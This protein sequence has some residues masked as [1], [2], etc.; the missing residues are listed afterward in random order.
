MKQ[1]YPRCV[2][3]TSVGFLLVCLISIAHA[4]QALKISPSQWL[5]QISQASAQQSFHGTFIYRCDAQLVAMKII[6]ATDEGK[7]HEKLISLNGPA[8]EVIQDGQSVTSSLFR[9]KRAMGWGVKEAVGSFEQALD[10]HYKIVEIGE[11]RIAE[12]H[13]K[14][15]EIRPSDQYRYGFLIWLDSE[16]GLVLRSDMADETGQVI[17]QIM[18]IDVEMITQREADA[19][20]GIVEVEQLEVSP[21][22]ELAK[23]TDSNWRVA[24]IPSGFKFSER[25]L[26]QAASG[27]EQLQEQLVF[28]DGLASVSVFIEPRKAS[29]QPLLGQTR[30]GA[31][32]VFG[33]VVREHQITVVG[34]VPKATVESIASSVS[35]QQ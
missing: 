27:G 22:T 30:I 28:T 23:L 20:I 5:Q 17:E 24:N 4:G 3:V 6:H 25:Y 7:G 26:R 11:D 32:N 14:V 34:D 12:R 21:T 15:V 16:T 19:M 10:A 9:G 8:H 13:T 1:H 18:F 31:V 29:E 35:Y 33:K 2:A